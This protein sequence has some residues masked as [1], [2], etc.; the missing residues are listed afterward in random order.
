MRAFAAQLEKQT[1]W[2]SVRYKGNGVFD[3]DYGVQSR[4]GHDFVFPLLPRGSSIQPFVVI[5]K[6]ADGAVLINAPAFVGTGPTT[7]LGLMNNMGGSPDDRME[8]SH[9]IEGRFTVTA[10]GKVLTN[11]TEEGGRE[12]DGTTVLTWQVDKGSDKIPEALI[13]PD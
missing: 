2:R 8:R 12:T 3:V 9:A 13:R 6:R 1:G 10:T 7:L 11:N 4:L 5:R